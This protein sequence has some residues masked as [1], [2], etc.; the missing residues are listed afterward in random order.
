M[1]N[2]LSDQLRV[3][4]DEILR[5]AVEI[6]ERVGVGGDAEVVIERGKDLGERDGPV[7]GLAGQAAGGADHLPGAHAASGQ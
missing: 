1:L 2:Q 3:V 7:D 5:A 4:F 6:D